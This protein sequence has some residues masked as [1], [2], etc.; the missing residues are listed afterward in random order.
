MPRAR[1]ALAPDGT[2]LHPASVQWLDDFLPDPS[3][4]RLKR[5]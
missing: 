3:V 1:T 4:N 5:S 2:R